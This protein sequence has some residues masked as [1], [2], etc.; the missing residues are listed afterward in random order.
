MRM[1]DIIDKK[2]RGNILT[3]DEIDFVIEGFTKGSIPD[4]QMSAFLMAVWFMGMNE[5]E[6]YNLTMAMRDSGDK[7]DLSKI[8][9]I[10]VDKHSTG[11][12]GDKT[13]LIVGPIVAALGVPVAKMSGRGLGHTGGTIDKLESIEGFSTSISSEQF[14]NQVNEI[15]IAVAG[16]TANLA[17]AD[18]KIYALRDVTATVDNI[19]LIASSIMSKKLASGADAIVLDVKCGNGAFMKDEEMACRLAEAMVDIGKCAGKNVTAIVTDMNE[20][21]GRY[22]GNSLEVYEA[23]KCLSGEGDEKLM[24]VCRVLA[25]YMLMSAKKAE[26]YPNAVAMVEEVISSGAALN[27]MK[28]FVEAQNG[29]KSLI[30][31]I[32]L[33]PRAEIQLQVYAP[34]SGYIDSM[35]TELVGK[36]CLALGGGRDTKDSVID[37]SVGIYLNKKT[38]EYVS[39]GDVVA[40]LFASD[41][42]KGQEAR[43]ILQ[44]AYSFA[45]NMS[46]KNRRII[47]K[48]IL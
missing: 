17:P 30:D 29:K 47:K 24:E 7:L 41:E 20:P 48:I 42:G 37:L 38:G 46:E 3:K 8:Q 10:K 36:A 39:E 28:E 15:G 32:S 14:I 4:Y 19:S 13:T 43:I 40:T 1:Y 6:T 33:L 21:L 31:D 35:N 18:K 5:D 9:G 16:Q 22:V 12:V 2:K 34:T 23:V 27:K 45:E 44:K 25:A 11:G 26:D